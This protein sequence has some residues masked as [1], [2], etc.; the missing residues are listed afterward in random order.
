M[1]QVELYDQHAATV[2]DT[3]TELPCAAGQ[4]REIFVVERIRKIRQSAGRT[5]QVTEFSLGDGDLRLAAC[6][7]LATSSCCARKSL[8]DASSG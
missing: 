6:W 8:R 7:R 1:D 5:L 4:L 3:F 2:D